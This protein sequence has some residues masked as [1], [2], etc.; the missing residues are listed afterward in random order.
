MDI[1]K[2]AKVTKISEIMLNNFKRNNCSGTIFQGINIVID[3]IE[4]EPETFNLLALRSFGESLYHSIT[5]AS[6]EF[7]FKSL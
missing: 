4:D 3:K 7:G 5:D 6:L 2:V 1:T